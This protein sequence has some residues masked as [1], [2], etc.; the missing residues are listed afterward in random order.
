[1]SV[2]DMANKGSPSE[3][4]DAI[5]KDNLDI[6]Y[7]DALNT[8]TWTQAKQMTPTSLTCTDNEDTNIGRR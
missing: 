7:T 8:D 2:K 1:M 6:T 4:M 5:H 3:N